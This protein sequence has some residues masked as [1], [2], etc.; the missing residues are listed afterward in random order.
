MEVVAPPQLL[1]VLTCR[2]PSPRQILLSTYS[3]CSLE[4]QEGELDRAGRSLKQD[5]YIG[6]NSR[7]TPWRQMQP[8]QHR[9]RPR[10]RLA[11]WSD[12]SDPE[13]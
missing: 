1:L 11:F 12:P 7:D 5:Y 4:K 8:G 2:A 9:S 6:M 13:V 10:A 3:P